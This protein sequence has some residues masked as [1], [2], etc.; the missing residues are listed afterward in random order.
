MA[1]QYT[2]LATDLVTNK[3]VGELPVNNVSLDA[4]LNSAGNMTAGGHLDDPRIDND[5]FIARTEPGRTAFWAYRENQ[6]V[7]G[8]IIWSREWQSNGK[9]LTITGQTFESYAARRYPRSWLGTAVLN[10]DQGQCSIIDGL[11]AGMQSVTNGNIG[12]LGYGIYSPSDVVRQ[13]TVNGW[14]LSQ[15]FDDYIQ[16]ILTF[17]DG[18]DYTITWQTDTHG[19][20]IKQL[21][22]QPRI[23]NPVGVTDLVV[24]YPGA[25][26]D[27]VYNENA[28]NGANQWWAVGD[29]TDAATTVGVATDSGTLGSGWPLLESVN[30]YSGVTDSTTINSHASSD[31]QSLPMPLVTHNAD[32]AGQGFPQFGSYGMGDYVVVNVI[33]PRF[34]EGNQ[35]AV[36]AIGWTIQPPDEG[37]GTETVTLVFDEATGGGGS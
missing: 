19:L 37:Q 17:S 11:W 18:C 25:V 22:V 20:P 7:W 26:S 3:I 4:Q 14:D 31:L 16:S 33:D 23:G 28:S 1:A 27:Y 13:L 29:G 10:L 2:Y 32:I 35:F 12:V 21:V 8:G 30:N 24:D 9:S 6:I 36:R 15:S 5:D 34:P